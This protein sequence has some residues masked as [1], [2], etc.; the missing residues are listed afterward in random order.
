MK[1]TEH[2]ILKTLLLALNGKVIV[3]LPKSADTLFR[4]ITFQIT[5]IWNEIWKTSGYFCFFKKKKII[6]NIYIH[7]WKEIQFAKPTFF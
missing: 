4:H 5:V 2:S 1:T 3:K 7:I 6:K